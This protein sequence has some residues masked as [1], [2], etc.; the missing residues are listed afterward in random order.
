[1]IIAVDVHYRDDLARSASI[2]FEDWSADEAIKIHVVDIDEVA[3][4]IPGQFYK[5]EL[6][7]AS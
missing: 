4:Y 3:E 7:N 5:R 6:Q 2:E 1:M